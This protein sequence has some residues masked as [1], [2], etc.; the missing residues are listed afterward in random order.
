MKS[1]TIT[2]RTGSAF[3]FDVSEVEDWTGAVKQLCAPKGIAFP[4]DVQRMD[5]IDSEHPIVEET[6]APPVRDCCS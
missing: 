2:T 6:K 3:T 4:R 1:I 5:I